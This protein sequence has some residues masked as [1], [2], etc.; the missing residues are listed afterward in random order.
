MKE[1]FVAYVGK[2][3]GSADI[4]AVLVEAN[5]AYDYTVKVLT[6]GPDDEAKFGK[7]VLDSYAS[8]RRDPEIGGDYLGVGGYDLELLHTTV[9]QMAG[10][11]YDPHDRDA[12]QRL[13]RQLFADFGTDALHCLVVD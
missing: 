8:N 7:I 10:G 5:K 1:A 4:E 3:V 2:A 12:D 11:R 13:A 9:L 6:A